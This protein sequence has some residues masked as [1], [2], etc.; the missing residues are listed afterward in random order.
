[1][2][3]SELAASQRVKPPKDI[4]SIASGFPEDEDI[5]EFLEEIYSARK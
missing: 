2:S 5:D 1:M 4:S 3:L